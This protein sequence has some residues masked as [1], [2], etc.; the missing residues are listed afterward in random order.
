MIL[1]NFLNE[2][3]LLGSMD[4]ESKLHSVT[5]HPVCRIT[6]VNNVTPVSFSKKKN[7]PKK[8]KN[9]IPDN[10][11]INTRISPPATA[12]SHTCVPVWN[13][14]IHSYVEREEHE[15]TPLIGGAT[16]SVGA[17]TAAPSGPC[18]SVATQGVAVTPTGVAATP[19]GSKKIP[20]CVHLPSTLRKIL[21]SQGE[22]VSAC[23]RNTRIS[24]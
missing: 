20:T 6:S 13:I 7:T 24:D 3:F 12:Q 18:I 21:R 16:P 22:T 23:G 4:V 19:R 15:A 9:R 14:R 2:Q 17:P 1:T 10:E 8:S 5:L 11:G